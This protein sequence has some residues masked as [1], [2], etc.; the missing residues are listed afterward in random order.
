MHPLLQ[1]LISNK[2][3]WVFLVFVIYLAGIVLF[4]VVYFLLYRVHRDNFAFNSD[5]LG[6]Q[7]QIVA[8]STKQERVNTEKK[9]DLLNEL[10]P[11]LDN[12]DSKAF[13][14]TSEPI[15][16]VWVETPAA[17]YTYFAPTTTATFNSSQ[18]L[19]SRLRVEHVNGT[20][21]EISDGPFLPLPKN[22][23]GYRALC[24]QWRSL[25][26]ERMKELRRIEESFS[27]AAP[28]VWTFPD[29]VY[30][31]AITQ[32]TVGYGD[33][34]PNSTLVR[35]LVTIQTIFSATL[36]VLAINLA[37]TTDRIAMR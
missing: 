16:C 35:I 5:V 14:T 33:I 8:A 34:L 13:R 26:G 11:V 37:V 30:F 21:L 1:R 28:D 6:S 17:K 4:A 3:Q 29:F 32:A 23:E 2:N 7:K 25:M 15:A 20:L 36:V 22:I 31:S 27:T 19:P 18:M 9:L 12:F 24:S 10:Q